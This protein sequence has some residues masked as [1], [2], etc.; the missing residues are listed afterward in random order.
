MRK[1]Y[2]LFGLAFTLLLVALVLGLPQRALTPPPP[3]PERP[4]PP[5]ALIPSGQDSLQLGRLV[6][7]R[8][9]L[10]SPLVLADQAG[11][12]Q[13]LVDLDAR[14]V[15]AAARPPM[16]IALVIDRSGSMAGPK[17]A[18]AKQAAKALVER[19]ADDDE[20]ALVT[21]SSDFSVDLG[22]TRLKGQRARVLRAVDE[23]LD[24]G[25]TNLAGGLTAGLKALYGADTTRVRR[26]LLL[27]DGNANQG[28][29][30]PGTIA[31]LAAQGRQQGITVSTLGVGVDFNED[32]MTMVAQSAGGGYYY[33]RD[34]AAIAQAFDA[35]L[36]GLLNIAARQVEVGLELASGVHIDEVYGYR[37]ERR[38]DRVVVPVGDLASGAHRRIMIRLRADAVPA[39]TR[40]VANVVL[41]YQDARGE[42]DEE[43]QGA[44]S[45]AVV[46]D[47]GQVAA[48]QRPEVQEAFTTAEAAQVRAEAAATFASGDRQAAMRQVQQSLGALRLK[49]A[50]LNSPKVAAQVTAM[51]RTLDALGAAQ[52]ESEAGK[53]LVKSEKLRAYESFVY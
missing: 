26:V 12:L 39:G 22:L 11:G 52:P 19:L 7:L 10:A 14:D 31:S 36:E 28:L 45:V 32:L 51:E 33:A 44:L 5:Q 30:D 29:T 6:T 13:L 42:D 43:F 27:S 2:V 40:P 48:A 47:A 18:Q 41:A 20:V 35:E 23:I 49:N 16:S 15:K 34:G 46:A 9:L 50:A 1:T 3:T 4:L 53:D 38:G 25:G 24:G 21:Y 37:T 17:M 8:G